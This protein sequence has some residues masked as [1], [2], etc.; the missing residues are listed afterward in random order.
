MLARVKTQGKTL[1]HWETQAGV[2]PD[3]WLE[4]DGEVGFININRLQKVSLL[5]NKKKSRLGDPLMTILHKPN[6]T[7][8]YCN[9]CQELTG[10]YAMD[11]AQQQC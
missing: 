1:L 5:E 9:V 4:E 7:A 10:P 2:H 3:T 6:M 8:S 11:N